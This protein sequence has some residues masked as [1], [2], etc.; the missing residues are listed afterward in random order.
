MGGVY[1]AM[2]LF[3]SSL[4]ENTI[5]AYIISIMFNLSIWFI[6]IGAEVVDS[7]AGRKVFEHLSLSSHLSALVEG[8][9]RT[10]GL[11]FFFSVI[12]LFCF[13][14]ERVVESSRWR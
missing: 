11:V 9:I 1:A 3:A 12:V 4:T 7:E 8:T 10:N 14:A 2:D 5:V 13:L 6:G